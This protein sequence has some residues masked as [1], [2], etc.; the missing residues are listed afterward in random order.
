MA[1]FGRF[2]PS[3]QRRTILFQCA[4]LQIL[5]VCVMS[6][7]AWLGAPMIV[8]LVLL[9]LACGLSLFV[10]TSGKFG[11]PGAL[12]FVFAAGASMSTALTLEQVVERTVIT[13]VVAMLAWLICWASETFRHQPTP[14]RAFPEEPGRPLSHRLIAA[15]RSSAGAAI[16]ICV[17]LAFDVQH[18]EWA[19]MGALAVMQGAHLHISMN[20]ALQRLV[21]TVIG[22]LLAWILLMQYPSVWTVIGILLVLNVATEVVIGINYAF[23]QIFV[24]PMALLMTYLGAA[25]TVG[26][27]M[28]PERVLSTLVGAAVGIGAALLLSSLDE[29]RFLASHHQSRK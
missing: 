12:I 7:V 19:A 24:T 15:A 11:A 28:A 9:A 29:R 13:A 16:A 18:P 3:S 5:T 27:E 14:E 2:A 10:C 6:T 8:Q 17:C 21:G 25:Q 20:R 23:G 26:P 22:A 4:L 1:L